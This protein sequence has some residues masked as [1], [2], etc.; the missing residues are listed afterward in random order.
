MLK[1]GDLWDEVVLEQKKKAPNPCVA[2]YGPGPAGKRCK[3]CRLLYA[4]HYSGTYYKCKLRTNTNGPGT[5]H[6]VNW[7]ACGKFDE[8]DNPCKM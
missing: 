5:D 6:R 7:P 4:K 1:F 2:L 8:R 3:D